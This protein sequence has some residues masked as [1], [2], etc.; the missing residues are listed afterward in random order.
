LLL[1]VGAVECPC[2]TSALQRSGC[3]CPVLSTCDIDSHKGTPDTSWPGLHPAVRPHAHI[4]T[5]PVL[6]NTNSTR[7]AAAALH[8]LHLSAFC[9]MRHAT[10]QGSHVVWEVPNSRVVVDDC[11]SGVIPGPDTLPS[12]SPT[13]VMTGLVAGGGKSEG[14]WHSELLVRGH[15]ASRPVGRPQR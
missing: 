6:M 7:A 15:G 3:Q 11:R 13:S 12:D 8:M 14:Q 5:T 2:N 1:L 10:A 9:N 4:T